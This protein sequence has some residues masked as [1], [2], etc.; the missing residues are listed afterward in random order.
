MPETIQKIL[1]LVEGEKT[2]RALMQRLLKLYGIDAKYEI[3]S[4]RTNIYALYDA[5][6]VL[7]DEKAMDLLLLLKSRERDAKKKAI[8]DDDY[9]DIL[10]VFDL[11]PQDTQFSPEK[12]QHMVEYFNE[13]TD[14]GKLYLNYPMVEAFYHM[15]S[16]P[17]EEFND[18]IVMLPELRRYKMRV[19]QESSTGD[20]RKFAA[21]REDCTIV[22]RQQLQKAHW[23]L[24][25]VS[26]ERLSPDQAAILTAQLKLITE[27]HHVSV[28]STCAFFIPDYNPALLA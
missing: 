23:L 15:K 2:D 18:R 7:E 21:S 8:F 22:I 10:L 16:I 6:F 17:D 25:S 27:N 1:L 24:Q 13:S 12:I 3:V 4:Y 11:D 26:G 19:N 5:L 14:K 20:Y 28:L 9:T